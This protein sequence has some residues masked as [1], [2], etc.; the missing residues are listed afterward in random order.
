MVA[1]RPNTAD[2][3][4]ERI[5]ERAGTPAQTPSEQQ[6]R[7][8]ESRVREI[9]VRPGTVGAH[10]EKKL[11][12][13]NHIFVDLYKPKGMEKKASNQMTAFIYQEFRKVH[14]T[15]VQLQ[16][17]QPHN[18]WDCISVFLRSLPSCFAEVSVYG[19]EG[20]YTD[21]EDRRSY[22]EKFG[23]G[24]G[25]N[26][27]GTF[28]PFS[29]KILLCFTLLHTYMQ[30]GNGNEYNE[31]SI[32]LNNQKSVFSHNLVSSVESFFEAFENLC[33]A[34]KAFDREPKLQKFREFVSRFDETY[35]YAEQR[36]LSEA[37]ES[38]VR[39]RAIFDDLRTATVPRPD[40][41]TFK[42]YQESRA[43][44]LLSQLSCIANDFGYIRGNMPSEFSVGNKTS[45]E[46]CVNDEQ[47]IEGSTPLSVKLICMKALKGYEGLISQASKWP[48]YAPLLFSKNTPLFQDIAETSLWWNHAVDC[49]IPSRFRDLQVLEQEGLIAKFGALP[50]EYPKAGLERCTEYLARQHI[51]HCILTDKKQVIGFDIPWT[52]RPIWQF[53]QEKLNDFDAFNMEN[54]RNALCGCPHAYYLQRLREYFK[55]Q[56]LNIFPN[57]W[58]AF[59]SIDV[60]QTMA[61]SR[62]ELWGAL[63][64]MGI[65]FSER[66]F[67]DF[68]TFLDA[69]GN[70]TISLKEFEQGMSSE[71]DI[72]SILES[73]QLCK[74]QN[75][76]LPLA[77]DEVD[78]EVR[79]TI[80]S[81]Q[82]LNVTMKCGAMKA[83]L[84][85]GM[86]RQST[87][88]TSVASKR[89]SKKDS[90]NPRDKYTRA[91]TMS[92]SMSFAEQNK[93]KIRML[94]KRAVMKILIRRDQVI[95][96][97]RLENMTFDDKLNIRGVEQER[98]EQTRFNIM[99]SAVCGI[100]S[101]ILLDETTKPYWTW[102]SMVAFHPARDE[103]E[104][105]DS[106][107]R[108]MID[109]CQHKAIALRGRRTRLGRTVLPMQ[110][111]LGSQ[112]NS[113]EDHSIPGTI[114]SELLQQHKEAEPK[115]RLELDFPSKTTIGVERALEPTRKMTE[116]NFSIFL[117][118]FVEDVFASTSTKPMSLKR[119]L[120]AVKK[121]FSGPRANTADQTSSKMMNSLPLDGAAPPAR[122]APASRAGHVG[123]RRPNALVVDDREDRPTTEEW[124]TGTLPT[125]NDLEENVFHIKNEYDSI[126]E[127]AKHNAP[128]PTVKK[129]KIFIDSP[130]LTKSWRKIPNLGLPKPSQDAKGLYQC[131]M[132]FKTKIK[133][134]DPE[135]VWK[136]QNQE[137]EKQIWGTRS[138]GPSPR[139]QKRVLSAPNVRKG[140]TPK[141]NAAVLVK[142]I[143]Q[144][145]SEK[146]APAK[147]QNV[148][149]KSAPS[150]Q[151]VKQVQ[152]IQEVQP[153][154]QQ[155]VVLPK[156]KVVQQQ[157]LPSIVNLSERA[158]SFGTTRIESGKFS[159]RS[160]WMSSGK[161]LLPGVALC[162]SPLAVEEFSTP[163]ID[164]SSGYTD[165]ST[166]TNHADSTDYEDTDWSI[167]RTNHADST[168]YED[169]GEK[170]KDLNRRIPRAR[171][172]AQGFCDR[173][174][175]KDYERSRSRERVFEPSIKLN[176]DIMLGSLKEIQFTFAGV[177]NTITE[178]MMESDC[179]PWYLQGVTTLILLRMFFFY[180]W[181]QP[182]YMY[183]F[184]ERYGCSWT[185]GHHLYGGNIKNPLKID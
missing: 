47:E 36:L 10:L 141:S 146:S 59:R 178:K 136:R 126:F 182:S 50:Y 58:M 76:G 24:F 63:K 142:T 181:A 147:F 125:T 93:I 112:Q 134:F 90:T 127:R 133:V 27:D 64:E 34:I 145:E 6:R 18:E 19:R 65:A 56:I 84:P 176:D 7:R 152:Q 79:S 92:E 115:D 41:D 9:Q 77:S 138:R 5:R 62:G 82:R 68:Y 108:E 175:Y 55:T 183:H 131:R 20:W 107:H 39:F 121:M 4:M 91:S 172:R 86:K 153:Q 170:E 120:P 11:R 28:E 99:V 180:Y 74:L 109:H 75:F 87:V 26:E 31:A 94:W 154:P 162:G 21:A 173:D 119:Y 105:V 129:G 14:D 89:N 137:W 164:V 23:F 67:E 184:Q 40:G 49:M 69:D 2:P 95:L 155:K 25:L 185:V 78:A 104:L 96:R 44:T 179:G 102:L 30:Q 110:V 124:P 72:H 29:H 61:L 130:F 132:H 166:R 1:S 38:I 106:P 116:Q 16:Q 35:C 177:I 157:L 122:E 73:C 15:F 13:P 139:R 148:A 60:D 163:A 169:A 144:V 128:S 113:L 123:G 98:I 167:I 103:M 101:R 118:Q 42:P 158:V 32:S 83:R 100:A 88:R 12:L 71:Y 66:D 111:K 85:P 165:W 174:K 33:H 151:Q 37:N 46:K 70:G 48:I 22:R 117:T 97:K 81:T 156:P 3:L 45:F 143:A 80:L 43:A 149:P 135:S 150:S 168:D 161:G 52:I 114:R 17:C 57:V 53:L 159:Y 51:L 171:T 54:F 160:P 140:S 8:Y